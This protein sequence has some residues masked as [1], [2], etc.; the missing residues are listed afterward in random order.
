MA[1]TIGIV[2]CQFFENYVQTINSKQMKKL[3]NV[4]RAIKLYSHTFVAA[5]FVVALTFASNQLIASPKANESVSM[6]KEHC[7]KTAKV[8]DW[9]W[10]VSG[11][12]DSDKDGDTCMTCSLVEERTWG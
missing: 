5:C 10:Q 4:G 2:N 6:D 7:Y 12:N 11:S 3:E 8:S 1:L 9:I